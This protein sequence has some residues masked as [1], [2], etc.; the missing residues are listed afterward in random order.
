MK[1]RVDMVA[2]ELAAKLWGGSWRTR[3]PYATAGEIPRSEA[4]SPAARPL[5]FVKLSVLTKRKSMCAVA[6][7]R[8]PASALRARLWPRAAAVLAALAQLPDDEAVAVL[9]AALRRR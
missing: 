7:K 9:R 8:L 2:C 6:Q 5:C 3:Q 4:A 1:S